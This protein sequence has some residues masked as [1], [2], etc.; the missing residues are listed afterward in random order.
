MIEMLRCLVALSA[1]GMIGVSFGLIQ[2]AANRRYQ[3]LQATG[4]FNTGW[5][6]MPSS[7]RRVAYLLMALALVQLVCPLLFT[8]TAQW[9]VT[10]GVVC[11]YGAV[12]YWQLRKRLA[13]A[14]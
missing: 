12:L 1:G 11:G 9:W 4:K 8:G 5:A 2:D 3:R 14:R 13:Q 7:M 10:G 6:V